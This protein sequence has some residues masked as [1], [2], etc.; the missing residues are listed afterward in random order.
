M[1]VI[2]N[3]VKIM[4]RLLMSG[5]M[6]LFDGINPPK[7]TL[8]VRITLVHHS[9]VLLSLRVDHIKLGEQAS[10]F[11]L[12]GV[13]HPGL[14]EGLQLESWRIVVVIA[15]DRIIGVFKSSRRM[16]ESSW[17]DVEIGH[18]L[19]A[20]A[21]VWVDFADL[22]SDDVV[23]VLHIDALR[24]ARDHHQRISVLISR[25]GL[26]DQLVGN[27]ILASFERLCYFFPVSDEHIPH[28][29]MIVPQCPKS[30]CHRIAHVI[31]RP[32]MLTALQRV[33]IFIESEG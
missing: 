8:Q 11:Q 16:G 18:W 27:H 26:V 33:S 30:L 29:V 10:G 22:S 17:K 9:D 32:R 1:L 2:Q 15:E 3:G 24:E 13:F 12:F 4:L 14:H 20:D 23:G 28:S 19:V 21:V 6:S 5:Q 25:P 31:L 7:P